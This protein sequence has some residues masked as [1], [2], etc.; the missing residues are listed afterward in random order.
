MK[1]T[2]AVLSALL[3]SACVALPAT[4]DPV[5]LRGDVTISRQFPGVAPA[6]ILGRHFENGTQLFDFDIS[7]NLDVAVNPLVTCRF[8]GCSPGSSMSLDMT[9]SPSPADTTIGTVK[10]IR[11]ENFVVGQGSLRFTGAM[12]LPAGQPHNS[13]QITAPFEAVGHLEFASNADDLSRG[14]SFYAADLASTGTVFGLFTAAATSFG[15]EPTRWFIENLDYV[16][17]PEHILD[18]GSSLSSTPEPASI[19]L[20]GVGIAGVAAKRRSLRGAR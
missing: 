6:H 13:I 10:G 18:G 17:D 5:T 16:F 3:I 12:T 9:L 4:A 7:T 2:P 14:V 11:Y 8:P 1:P 19:L 20:I 15:N